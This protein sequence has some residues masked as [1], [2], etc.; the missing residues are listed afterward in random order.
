MQTIVTL[1][2]HGD[3]LRSYYVLYYKPIP[4]VA[5]EGT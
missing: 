2:K 4:R 1:G 3:I 5:Y